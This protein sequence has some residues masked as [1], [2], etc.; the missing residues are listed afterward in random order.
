MSFD[1]IVMCPTCGDSWYECADYDE[2]FNCDK[3][4]HKNIEPEEIDLVSQKLGVKIIFTIHYRQIYRAY[5]N[6]PI[7]RV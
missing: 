3:C 1:A 4:G 7:E 2:T 5:D 6:E